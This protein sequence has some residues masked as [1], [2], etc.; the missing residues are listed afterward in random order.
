MAEGGETTRP[1][2]RPEGAESVKVVEALDEWSEDPGPPKDSR[3]FTCRCVGL[4]SLAFVLGGIV[5]ALSIFIMFAR[6]ETEIPSNLCEGVETAETFTLTGEH[7]CQ[8]YNLC[9]SGGDHNEEGGVVCGA[10]SS[11]RVSVT[12]FDE[13][14][15]RALFWLFLSK[16]G[17]DTYAK[18]AKGCPANLCREVV[19]SVDGDMAATAVFHDVP[20]DSER[21][22]MVLHDMDGDSKLKTNWLG[23]PREGLAASRGAKGGP[24]GG[25]SWDNAKFR[26]DPSHC[27]MTENVPMWYM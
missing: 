1:E 15:G 16:A 4:G 7:N 20:H 26:I 11:V 21:A 19:A 25:P 10:V 24:F 18:K 9:E 17:W 22:F 3:W 13:Q 5:G 14:G 27:N 23:M 8:D 12:D 2:G 6:E